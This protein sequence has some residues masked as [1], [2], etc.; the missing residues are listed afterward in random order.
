M[1]KFT[2]ISGSAYSGKSK[3][4]VSFFDGCDNVKYLCTGRTIDTPTMEKIIFLESSRNVSWSIERDFRFENY[5][6]MVQEYKYF[7]LD[8]VTVSAMD[9]YIY[10]S[11]QF[12]ISGYDK[13]E[14]IGKLLREQITDF[15]NAV[16]SKDGSIVAVTNE[17]GFYHDL[18]G[19]HYG[20]FCIALS[21]INTRLAAIADEV[22]FSVS[23]VQ[24]RIK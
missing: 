14:K 6:A 19:E 17:I 8:S 16:K 15:I 5:A 11:N 12:D 1:G 7:I 20:H 9:Y 22:Y 24:F 4:A 13:G 2:L 18:F 23:G 3:W 10:G 21:T